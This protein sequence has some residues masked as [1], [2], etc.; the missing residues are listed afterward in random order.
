M[1]L[2]PSLERLIEWEETTFYTY[3][4]NENPEGRI[5]DSPFWIKVKVGV[6]GLLF[7]FSDPQVDL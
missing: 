2:I 6:N 1:F 3:S 4:H 5:L 7:R